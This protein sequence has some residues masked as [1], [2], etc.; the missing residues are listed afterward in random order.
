MWRQ[1]LIVIL[2]LAAAV[3]IVALGIRGLL[4]DTLIRPLLYAVWGAIRI[5]ESIPQG[6]IWLAFVA[7]TGIVALVS[8][9]G[10][11]AERGPP[12]PGYCSTRARL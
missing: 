7:A 6:M 10:G 2:A 9:W 3:E 1:R 4:E 8:I 11:T 5:F 12:Q